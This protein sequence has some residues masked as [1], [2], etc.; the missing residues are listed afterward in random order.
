MFNF[1]KRINKYLCFSEKQKPIETLFHVHAPLLFHQ[2]KDVRVASSRLLSASKSDNS[3]PLS[4]M[5]IRIGY[6]K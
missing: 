6:K 2:M 1:I 5:F 3:A 4:S